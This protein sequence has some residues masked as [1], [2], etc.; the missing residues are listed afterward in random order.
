MSE[1]PKN[2]DNTALHK[3]SE[4]VE[5]LKKWLGVSE[6]HLGP[7]K[8]LCDN[9]DNVNNLLES[10]MQDISN[11]FIQIATKFQEQNQRITELA[12]QGEHDSIPKDA[13]VSIKQEMDDIDQLIGKIIV[14]MQFQD[15]VSQN[16]VITH[17]V[18][19]TIIEYVKD[20]ENL[21][22]EHLNGKTGAVAIDIDFVSKIISCLS[23]GDLR[24]NFTDYLVSQ[25]HI[26]DSSE[27]GYMP[28]DSDDQGDDSFDLF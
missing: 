26:K 24:S 8:L 27:I 16:I 15:R 18:M 1:K 12:S 23:L 19:N 20:N 11:D 3:V 14:S 25:G 21:T 7:T 2:I 4:D 10:S 17:K 28:P 6:S 22:A 13:L 9:L 5:M